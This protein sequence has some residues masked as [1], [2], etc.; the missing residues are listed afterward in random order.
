MSQF[1]AL[2]GAL[3]G[4]RAGGS[5]WRRGPTQG[6]FRHYL[7]PSRGCSSE[8]VPSAVASSSNYVE[9]MYFAWLE[10]HKSVHKVTSVRCLHFNDDND[11]F[12]F[13]YYLCGRILFIINL[14]LFT[15]KCLSARA[16]NSIFN[17]FDM[18]ICAKIYRCGNWP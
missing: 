4:G 3:R 10:D 13:A 17:F 6:P 2:V 7:D 14:M 1:R 8:A 5:W 12:L 16:K 9:E 11:F 18:K 15:Q